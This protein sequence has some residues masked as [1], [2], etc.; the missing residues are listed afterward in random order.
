MSNAGHFHPRFRIVAGRDRRLQELGLSPFVYHAA[1]NLQLL[2]RARTA[3]VSMRLPF[4]L[5]TGAF[6]SA[7]PARWLDGPEGLRPFLGDLSEEVP[8]RT[9]AG[10]GRG[11]ARQVRFQ[12]ADAPGRPYPFDFLV[13]AGLDIRTKPIGLIALRDILRHFAVETE[14]PQRFGDAG[15]PIEL[16]RLLLHPLTEWQR[17][18]YRCPE[19]QREVWG[20][21]GLHLICGDHNRRMAVVAER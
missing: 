14:G 5:D 21:P 1:V 13:V 16:P 15:E 19:C 18:R 20:R 6:A 9:A 10:E 4:R 3:R 7:I 17:I 8:F 12:F 11:P 2:G